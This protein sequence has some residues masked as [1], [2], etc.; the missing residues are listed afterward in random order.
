MAQEVRPTSVE[1]DHHAP[2][3]LR[4][5]APATKSSAAAGPSLPSPPT[6]DGS[7][8][9]WRPSLARPPSLPPTGGGATIRSL[10]TNVTIVMHLGPFYYFFISYFFWF[11]KN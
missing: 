1:V 4:S 11:L 5:L 6:P 7:P 9:A 8:L 10:F 2:R 3:G